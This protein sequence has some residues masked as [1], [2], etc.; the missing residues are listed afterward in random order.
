MLSLLH[1]LLKILHKHFLLNDHLNY[2]IHL[3]LIIHHVLLI[4][5]K[6]LRKNFQNVLMLLVMLRHLLCFLMLLRLLFEDFDIGFWIEVFVIL[7]ACCEYGYIFHRD[8]MLRFWSRNYSLLCFFIFFLF[9][10]RF[11]VIYLKLKKSYQ[12][13]MIAIYCLFFGHLPAAQLK[14]VIMLNVFKP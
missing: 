13:H 12:K 2:H 7:L 14:K 1:F 9:F 6:Y 3:I 8:D 4:L 10:S 11:F 5:K